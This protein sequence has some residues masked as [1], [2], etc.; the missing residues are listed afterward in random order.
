MVFPANPTQIPGLT[1]HGLPY[2][3]VFCARAHGHTSR[4]LGPSIFGVSIPSLSILRRADPGSLNIRGVDP[5]A[6][7]SSACRPF[8]S[9]FCEAGQNLS[10][11]WG[12]RGMGC[13]LRAFSVLEHMATR[14][15]PRS[16]H[17]SGR[18]PPACLFLGSSIAHGDPSMLESSCF[19]VV[20]CHPLCHPPYFCVVPCHPR[21]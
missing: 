4:P 6:L 8:V 16:L 9:P 12:S 20:P 1:R 10:K 11:S 19:C 17:F 14:V 7:H 18:R 21:F 2:A 15:Y 3:R 13:C 5:Q